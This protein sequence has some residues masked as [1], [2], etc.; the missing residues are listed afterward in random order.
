MA[1]NRHEQLIYKATNNSFKENV[2]QEELFEIADEC[3][4]LLGKKRLSCVS[5]CDC[6]SEASVLVFVEV[7]KD[8]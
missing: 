4:K 6:D 8:F 7:Q 3:A 5:L 2:D 1:N